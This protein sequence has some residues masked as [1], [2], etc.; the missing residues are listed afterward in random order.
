MILSLVENDFDGM[1]LLLATGVKSVSKLILS[2]AK[3]VKH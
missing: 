3:G 2:S 1:E